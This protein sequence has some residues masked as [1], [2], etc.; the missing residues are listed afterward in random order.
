MEEVNPYTI[1]SGPLFEPIMPPALRGSAHSVSP[2]P[3]S[4][5]IITKK[6]GTW[7]LSSEVL[8]CS[9]GSSADYVNHWMIVVDRL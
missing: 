4:S 7:K 5:T 6:N 3:T 8:R 1:E 2:G 9:N